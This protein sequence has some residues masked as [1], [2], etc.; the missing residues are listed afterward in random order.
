MAAFEVR[1]LNQRD[2]EWVSRFV[3]DRWGSARMVSRGRVH[4]VDALP[5]FIALQDDRPAGLTTYQIEG[6]QCE[7]VTLDSLVEGIGIGSA[8]I[9]AVKDAA[10]RAGCARLWLLTTN[11]N[12]PAL[13]FYQK[14]GFVLAALHRNAM[15]QTRKLKPEVPLIGIDGIPLRDE[16]ELELEVGG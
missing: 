7:M 1:A 13:R 4:Q 10:L 2:A 12:M 16:I 8:L 3:V 14:R 6:D 5:G 15:E 11:D 9:A